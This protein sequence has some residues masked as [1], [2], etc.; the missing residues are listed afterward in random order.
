MRLGLFQDRRVNRGAIPFWHLLGQQP[1]GEVA[2]VVDARAAVRVEAVVVAEQIAL[3]GVVH[4]DRIGVRHVDLDR[5]QR[6]PGAVLLAYREVRR[7]VGRPVD[8]A[9][10]GSGG[11]GGSRAWRLSST[12]AWGAASER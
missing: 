4:V 1:G 10:G 12:G 5:A 8:V 7:A 9:R 6:V 3:V 11:G 2:D